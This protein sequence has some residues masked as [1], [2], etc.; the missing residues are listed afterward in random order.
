MYVRPWP[1]GH[2]L[3]DIKRSLSQP[4]DPYCV[5]AAHLVGRFGGTNGI[6][7]RGLADRVTYIERGET[8]SF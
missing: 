4:E 3:T 8:H 7:R 1:T 2:G 6:E 5:G